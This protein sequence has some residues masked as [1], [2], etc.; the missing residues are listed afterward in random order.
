MATLVSIE[1]NRQVEVPDNQVLELLRSEKFGLVPG[2]INEGVGELIHPSGEIY[3]VPVDQFYEHLEKGFK[4]ESEDS[5]KYKEM[6]KEYTGFLPAL[7][8]GGL[9][10]AKGASMSLSTPIMEGLGVDV[11]A[12]EHFQ[13]GPS[14]GGEVGGTLASL[15]YGGPALKGAALG[16]KGIAKAAALAP[17]AVA[18]GAQFAG[19]KTGAFLTAKMAKDTFGKKLLEKTTGA[20]VEGT[21]DGAIYGGAQAFHD[22]Q[23]RRSELTGQAVASH[24]LSGAQSG[25][26]AGAAFGGAIY[27][28]GI[29]VAGA[30]AKASGPAKK[31]LAG[32]MPIDNPT[33]VNTVEEFFEG[34][35]ENAAFDALGGRKKFQQ[36]IDK[37]GPEWESAAKRWFSKSQVVENG[38]DT[39]L[40]AAGD[41]WEDLARKL[42]TSQTDT[43]NKLGQ[44]YAE[45]DAA[46]NVKAG[47]DH[48]NLINRFQ[49]VQD[50]LGFVQSKHLR[51]DL[52]EV[53]EE[54]MR[55]AIASDL[56]KAMPGGERNQRLAVLGII[57]DTPQREVLAKLGG[58]KGKELRDLYGQYESTLG[59]AFARM[60]FNHAVKNKNTYYSRRKFDQVA[61]TDRRNQYGTVGAIWRDEI[62]DAAER[63]LTEVRG[64]EAAQEAIENFKNSKKYYGYASEFLDQAADKANAAKANRSVS[65]TD[66][67]L[68]SSILG[69]GIAGG[70]ALGAPGAMVGGM[71]GALGHRYLRE[72]GLSYTVAGARSLAVLAKRQESTISKIG[73]LA[74]RTARGV[75][76]KRGPVAFPF[77]TKTLSMITFTGNKPEGETRQELISSLVGQIET[78][79]GDPV[80]FAQRISSELGEINII[81]P[82]V[83]KEIVASKARMINFLSEK[84]PRPGESYS[85][86]QPKLYANSYLTPDSMARFERHLYASMNPIDAVKNDLAD[87]TLT[88]ETIEAV[89]T[90]Y[91]ALFGELKRKIMEEMAGSD[92][93]LS[94]SELAQ[95]AKIF[96]ESITKYQ[97]PGFMR[98]QQKQFKKQAKSSTMGGLSKSSARVGR[99]EELVTTGPQAVTLNLRKS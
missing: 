31:M 90:I 69:G 61:E 92:K 51:A 98:R 52:D 42:E 13:P 28:L 91:P 6:E 50:D 64:K 75:T 39:P 83:A 53:I 5:K 11:E 26:I 87:G 22:T 63:V 97:S 67:M 9:G 40:I 68:G 70:A 2:V 73:Q 76:E 15:V 74:A 4:L 99:M 41:T 77:A 12:Y 21:I 48:R 44:F 25:A 84:A 36:L 10:L 46:T 24:V 45:L 3:E 18:K 7:A 17:A 86:L 71:I 80:S 88:S 19:G 62:D 81:A 38:V 96:N 85:K 32:A 89:E 29:P 33:N 59:D 58:M 23:L 35:A 54:T 30:M 94:Y 57:Y 56:T 37:R 49:E 78:L 79:T 95:V 65:L 27:A 93:V 1:E 55:D 43:G 16:V 72:R 34:V 60:D 82:E 47:I 8:A 66:Y 14:V 20:I